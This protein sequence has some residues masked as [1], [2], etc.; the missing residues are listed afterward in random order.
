MS[1]TGR[2]IQT[3]ASCKPQTTSPTARTGR[4]YSESKDGSTWRRFFV[5]LHK[6][7]GKT[8]VLPSQDSEDTHHFHLGL[9]A[10]WKV[11]KK[12]KKGGLQ[13][14]RLERDFPDRLLAVSVTWKPCTVVW[15]FC[16]LVGHC[17]ICTLGTELNIAWLALACSCHAKPI[18]GDCKRHTVQVSLHSLFSQKYH[19]SPT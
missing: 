11:K 16:I 12:N 17:A 10:N 6:T 19:H 5:A 2:I 7:V 8:E 14:R 15:F 13:T 1:W 3:W 4:D 9:N 18:H